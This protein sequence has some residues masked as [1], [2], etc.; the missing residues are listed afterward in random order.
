MKNTSHMKK[1]AI[2]IDS[3]ADLGIKSKRGEFENDEVLSVDEMAGLPRDRNKELATSA[4]DKGKNVQPNQTIYCTLW[5]LY[6]SW[7]SY[8]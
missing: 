7:S 5:K 6:L 2:V 3:G 1:D 8:Q 4:K